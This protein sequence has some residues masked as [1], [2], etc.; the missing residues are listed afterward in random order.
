MKQ[1]LRIAKFD[2]WLPFHIGIEKKKPKKDTPID[3]ENFINSPQ[4]GITYEKDNHKE[5]RLEDKR[6]IEEI[7]RLLKFKTCPICRT[8]M[9][10][11]PPDFNE[12]ILICLHCGFWGGRGSRMDNVYEQTPLRGFLGVYKPLKPLKDLESEYLITHLKRFPKDLPK[13]GPRRAEKF[14]I[15]LLADYLKCEVRPIGGTKDKGV[16]GYVIKNDK[17]NSI[18]QIKWRENINGA[19]S[20]KVI[21]E[22]AGTLLA[23]G[24]PSGILV[25]NKDHYSKDAIQDSALISKRKLDG[26]GAMRLSLVDYH[27]ILDML[28]I[29][30]TKLTTN[31]KIED[32]INIETGYDVF[33]GAMRLHQEFI[34]MFM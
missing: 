15:E 7:H 29:S 32:W 14:V 26:L 31:M 2:D 22:V 23:R 28:E 13:I 21:R 5:Y 1:N 8:R 33:E 20:V 24:I 34:N 18:I 3:W 4:F 19:E 30:S 9:T 25:S 27:N 16:D 11:R 6:A 10:K 12:A 17:I